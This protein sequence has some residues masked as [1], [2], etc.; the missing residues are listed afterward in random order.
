MK[1]T[2]LLFLLPFVLTACSSMSP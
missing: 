1:K 2:L